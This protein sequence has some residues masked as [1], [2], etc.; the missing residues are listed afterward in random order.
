MRNVLFS[1]SSMRYNGGAIMCL[2]EIIKY[3]NENIHP[4]VVLSGH[5]TTEDELKRR[6]IEY[7]VVRSYDWLVQ[8]EKKKSVT[9]KAKW[10]IQKLVN[11]KAEIQLFHILRKHKIDVL[12]INSVY[13]PAGVAA[14]RR[15]HIPVVWHIREFSEGAPET[16]SYWNARKSYRVMSQSDC[17]IGV[18]KCIC[19]WYQQKMP[20]AKIQLVYDGVDTE[21]IHPVLHPLFEKNRIGFFCQEVSHLLRDIRMRLR[22]WEFSK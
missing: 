11:I 19:E 5:G 3:S 9:G 7:Y 13:N 2:L 8:R 21:Q 12:H 22:L 18:S 4:I 15:M 17:M 10:L 1:S 20:D 14:A 16:P 6:N